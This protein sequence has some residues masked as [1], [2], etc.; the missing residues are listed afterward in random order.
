MIRVPGGFASGAYNPNAVVITGGSINGTPIGATTPS[1]GAFTTLSA[2][3]VTL[4][5]N[6]FQ[7]SPT[8]S[9][10]NYLQVTG[11]I[12]TGLPTLSAQGTEDRKSVV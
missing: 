12:A 9:A 3:G 8:A 5:A 10:V 2:S 6:D 4:I 7:V 11:A 1:T